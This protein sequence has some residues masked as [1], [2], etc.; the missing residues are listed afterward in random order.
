M[1]DLP[2]SMLLKPWNLPEVLRPG[3]RALN[4]VTKLHHRSVDRILNSVFHKSIF[5][6]HGFFPDGFGQYE[7]VSRY[8]EQIA[9]AR[10]SIPPI[11]RIGPLLGATHF[12]AREKISTQE[13]Q[14]TST[15]SGPLS[16]LPEESRQCYF[17][18][19]RP[20]HWEQQQ[21]KAAVVLL[22]AMGEF[23]YGWEFKIRMI[24]Y[25][26]CTHFLWLLFFS[27]SQHAL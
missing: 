9:D 17:E 14:F 23:K 6:P 25:N 1:R 19:V 8:A 21:H 22:P 26:I 15:L 27:Q 2:L 20:Q 4:R 12:N 18:L 10:R 5:H 11:T 13:G 7:L 24:V 3:I 16:D